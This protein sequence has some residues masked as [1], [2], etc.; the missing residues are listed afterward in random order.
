MIFQTN[1]HVTRYGMVVDVA[2]IRARLVTEGEATEVSV[3]CAGLEGQTWW[4]PA[5]KIDP[6]EVATSESIYD[7]FVVI[8]VQVECAGGDRMTMALKELGH[9]GYPHTK[10]RSV[11]IA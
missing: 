4:Q 5:D 10:L 8:T 11:S 6:A 9:D 3:Q 7:G 1:F 2:S